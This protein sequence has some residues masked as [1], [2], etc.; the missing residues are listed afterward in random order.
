MAILNNTAVSQGVKEAAGQTVICL[1]EYRP[2][3][4]AKCDMVNPMLLSLVQ[5]I[6]RSNA[7]GAG[8][9]FV[10]DRGSK[11]NTDEEDLDDDQLNQQLAQSMLDSMA[12]NIP[13]KY[14]TDAALKICSAVSSCFL[15][16]ALCICILT[17]SYYFAS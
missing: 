4:L 1:L 9:L 12:I 8:S 7:S 11:E 6:A 17:L 15:L 3:L 5:L 16:V 10:M 14:F 2:K 13:S